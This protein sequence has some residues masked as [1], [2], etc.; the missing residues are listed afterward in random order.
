MSRKHKSIIFD[1]ESYQTHF[2]ATKKLFSAKLPVLESELG[3]WSSQS[4]E[5]ERESPCDEK[6]S[7]LKLPNTY[8]L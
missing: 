5:K 1:R 8:K 2:V 4:R 6:V 3:P 7:S